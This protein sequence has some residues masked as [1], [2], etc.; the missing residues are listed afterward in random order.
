MNKKEMKLG[1]GLMRLPK[2]EDGIQIDIE[3]VKQMV[4]MFME[5]GFNYFDTAFTYDQG[6]SELAVKEALTDRYPRSSF[7]LATKLNAWLGCHD[8]ASALQEFETSLA[9]TGAGY[10]DNYLLHGISDSN[11]QLYD[12]YGIWDF[13]REQKEKG[14]IKQYGF[15]FHGTTDLLKKLLTDHPDVSFV[16]LQINYADWD[17][18]GVNAKENYEVVCSHDLPVYVMEPVKGGLLANLPP[19]A[20]DILRK[21]DPQASA[22][23][24]ALR[25]V[26]SLEGVKIVLSGM[27]DL[28]QMK[29]NLSFMKDFQPLT[30]AESETVNQVKTALRECRTIPCTGCHYCTAGCPKSICI[31]EIFD[32]MNIFET[33]HDLHSAEHHYEMKT[34]Q[35]GKA[36]DCVACGQCEKACPQHLKIITYLQQAKSIFE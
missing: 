3:Q 16:Q 17:D 23:S 6:R 5:A 34:K 13:V 30:E 33:Y 25:Y 14:L 36:G 29:D 1:F 10:F 12:D 22:A 18:P 35:S 32:I 19:Q 27:S 31:P 2:K 9:R 15:S 20:S 4:D 28:N 7:R 24:W 8:K 11:Y 21:A 26:A